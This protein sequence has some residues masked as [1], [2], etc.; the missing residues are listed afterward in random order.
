MISIKDINIIIKSI[1]I[2]MYNVVLYYILTNV[3]DK[4]LNFFCNNYI[5]Y[6]NYIDDFS[7]DE[8][9]INIYNKDYEKIISLFKINK[10][11][12]KYIN[13]KKYNTYNYI[14]IKSFLFNILDKNIDLY[15]FT[16][17]LVIIYKHKKQLNTNF[18]KKVTFSNYKYLYILYKDNYNNY[19]IAIIDLYANYNIIDKK[20]ILFNMINL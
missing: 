4:Y 2:F 8:C 18:I 14:I 10:T 15:I 1:L 9:N 17:K 7:D 16:N 11:L 3:N 6:N 19:K 12:E 13:K 20:M 5:N